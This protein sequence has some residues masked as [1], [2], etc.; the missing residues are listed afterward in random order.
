MHFDHFHG[1]P[2]LLP[3][4]MS[5]DTVLENERQSKPNRALFFFLLGLASTLVLGQARE[6]DG[7]DRMLLDGRFDTKRSGEKSDVHDPHK[8]FRTND[9]KHSWEK[10]DV[11]VP[12]KVFRTNVGELANLGSVDAVLYLHGCDGVRQ[13][14]S[15]W[16][17][18]LNELGLVVVMT[19]S[20]TTAQ[21]FYCGRGGGPKQEV[22][23][24]R[25]RDILSMR[26]AESVYALNQLHTISNVRRIFIVGFSLGGLTAFTSVRGYTGDDGA[27]VAP[28]TSKLAGVISLSSYC[29]TPLRV[30]E[31][32][33][34]LMINFVSDPSFPVERNQ[35][36]EKTAARTGT[37]KNVVL[38]GHGHATGQSRVAIDAVKDFINTYRSR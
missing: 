15:H 20:A 3:L 30:P 6:P 7:L 5:P 8:L 22:G 16:I 4:L 14:E 18:T 26:I 24:V 12:G 9:V 35:C 34:L 1:R 19:D 13:D 36:A 21:S 10:S 29:L 27:M 33:P 38:E 37:S 23:G 25:V 31:Q 28:L 17:S 32:T 2:R 11:S